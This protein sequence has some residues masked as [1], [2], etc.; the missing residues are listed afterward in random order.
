MSIFKD[1]ST[2][3]C[4]GFRERNAASN[5]YKLRLRFVRPGDP[6][7]A[8]EQKRLYEIAAC[9]GHEFAPSPVFVCGADKCLRCGH[10]V[11]RRP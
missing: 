2:P 5:E 10:I 11:A 9:P 7:S 3:V 1:G 8:E 4:E 6:L